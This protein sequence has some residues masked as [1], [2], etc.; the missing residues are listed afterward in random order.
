MSGNHE[1]PASDREL[2]VDIVRLVMR[3]QFPDLELGQVRHLGSGWEYD[4][5]LVDGSLVVRFPRYAEVAADLDHAE[6]VLRFVGAGVGSSVVVPKI[7]LRGRSS[8]HFPHRFFGHDLIPGVD[9]NDRRAPQSAGLASD[10]GRALTHIHSIPPT[11][12]AELGIGPQ[13]WFCRTAY[14]GLIRLVATAPGLR[15]VAPEA[16]AWLQGPPALPREYAGM[17]RFIHDDFQPE[18]IIVDEASGRLNGVIDWGGALGD[19]AQDFTFILP[20][21]GWPFTRAMLDAYGLPLDEDFEARLDFLGRVR[22][23][24]WLA[25]AVVQGESAH[26]SPAMVNNLFA[27]KQ[28]S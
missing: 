25:Y 3:E 26:V 15:E 1:P 13:K 6:A 10:L 23:L 22:A 16:Y 18:H 11:S 28:S 9:A 19:P 20:W 17:P 5:Y 27:S 12:A 2:N 21:R 4:A 8:I 7:T 24:G 14:D